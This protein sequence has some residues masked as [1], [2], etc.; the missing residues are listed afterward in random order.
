M[1]RFDTVEILGLVLVLLGLF[2]LR[3]LFA[4]RSGKVGGRMGDIFTNRKDA[5]GSSHQIYEVM[6]HEYAQEEARRTEL[7]EEAASNPRAARHLER[8]IQD[9]LKATDE[10]RR[11]MAEHRPA[12]KEGMQDMDLRRKEIEQE[13]D[14]VAA[15]IRHLNA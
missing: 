13:L 10:I 1:S 15:L 2:Q 11:Y 6:T 7:W 12:D 9:E 4:L 3:R 8:A 14:R 5:P